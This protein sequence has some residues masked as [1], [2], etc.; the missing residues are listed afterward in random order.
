MKQ[1][2]FLFFF[3]ATFSVSAFAQF[4]LGS[5]MSKIKAYFADN[6][7]YAS[8]QEFNTEDGTKAICFTKVK[9]V[10]DYTFYFDYYG[11]CSSYVVTYDRSELPDLTRR[12]DA[13]FCIEYNTKWIAEDNS[14]DITLIPSKTGENFFSIVYRGRMTGRFTINTLAFN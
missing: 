4:P 14:F 9:V 8:V 2:I 12:F 5:E 10:G 6:I 7:P 13:K 11:K 3:L 1:L